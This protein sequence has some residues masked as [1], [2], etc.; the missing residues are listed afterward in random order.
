L[1]IHL[2][3]LKQNNCFEQNQGQWSGQ[4]QIKGKSTVQGVANIDQIRSVTPTSMPCQQNRS[5]TAGLH[6]MR[7][8]FFSTSI[9]EATASSSYR[10]A[11]V[12]GF[13]RG[14]NLGWRLLSSVL[15]AFYSTSIGAS[16]MAFFRLN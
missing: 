13:A 8:Y 7:V 3:Q 5:A 11:P 14:C 1:L 2:N 9:S 10:S 4:L 12:D 6:G 15:L 16:P